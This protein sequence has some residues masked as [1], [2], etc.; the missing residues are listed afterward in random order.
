MESSENLPLGGDPRSRFAGLFYGVL[1]GIAFQEA[2]TPI[3][4]DFRLEDGPTLATIV[5]ALVFFLTSVRFL[6]GNELHLAQVKQHDNGWVWLIDF[7]VIV[8]EAFVMIFLG[9]ICSKQESAV[10]ARYGF[11]RVLA[12]LYAIDI[13]WIV[14]LQWLPTKLS[15]WNFYPH[16]FWKKVERDNVQLQW[17]GINLAALVLMG[18][19]SVAAHDVYSHTSSLIA[20]LFINFAAFIL[21]VKELIVQRKHV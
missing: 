6:Y 12:V 20:M 11:F 18:L 19:V 2:V 17:A 21:D 8:F 3:R 10:L 7:A 14:L 15:D 4:A 1:I 16:E 9:G 13:L 5:L